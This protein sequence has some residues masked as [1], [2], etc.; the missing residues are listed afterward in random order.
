[1]PAKQLASQKVPAE[2]VQQLLSKALAAGPT[3][4]WEQVRDKQ[5]LH[6][7]LCPAGGCTMIMS[8]HPSALLG[9]RL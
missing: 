8:S 4:V 1:M 2:G 6:I 7:R 3:T 9:G 5:A